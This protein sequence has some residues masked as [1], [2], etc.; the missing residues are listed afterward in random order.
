MDLLVSAALLSSS[1]DNAVAVASPSP[2]RNYTQ[3]HDLLRKITGALQFLLEEVQD[4]IHKL[5][6][7]L[8]TAGPSKV[9]LPINEAMLELTKII[10]H[11]L[12]T[13]APHSKKD[14]GR[15]TLSCLKG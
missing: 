10:W 14:G 12:P 15:S 5:L 2:S 9:A 8:Q 13:F 11:P 1:P 4:I 6:N 7:I 3:F